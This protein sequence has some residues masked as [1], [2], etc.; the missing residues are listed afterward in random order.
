MLHGEVFGSAFLDA[1][2]VCTYKHG[3]VVFVSSQ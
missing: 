1:S 2:S 3:I